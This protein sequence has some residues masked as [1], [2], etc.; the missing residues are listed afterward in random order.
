MEKHLGRCLTREEV[1]HYENEIKDNN[2]IE[3]LKLFKN[4]AEHNKYHK[5]LRR[6]RKSNEI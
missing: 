6:K 1:V 4:S 5:K 2:R 3:N